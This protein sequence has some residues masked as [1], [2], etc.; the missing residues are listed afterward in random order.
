ME[1]GGDV[2]GTQP[3]PVP[4]VRASRDGGKGGAIDAHGRREGDERG[5]SDRERV[6]QG[7]PASA[8]PKSEAAATKKGSRERCTR[9]GCA[10]GSEGAGDEDSGVVGCAWRWCCT[11]AS[12][13]AQATSRAPGAWRCSCVDDSPG[14]QRDATF[15]LKSVAVVARRAPAACAADAGGSSARRGDKGGAGNKGGL[16]QALHMRLAV[17]SRRGHRAAGGRGDVGS[18][19]RQHHMLG[20]QMAAL[21]GATALEPANHRNVR[22]GEAWASCVGVVGRQGHDARSTFGESVVAW[23]LTRGVLPAL[24]V[25]AA[26]VVRYVTAWRGPTVR[27]RNRA[28]CSRGVMDAGTS[29]ASAVAEGQAQR[30]ALL[31]PTGRQIGEARARSGEVE[32]QRRGMREQP[33]RIE[34]E[35]RWIERSRGLAEP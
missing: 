20:V 6:E 11:S 33:V 32:N 5:T 26:H 24:L 16:G 30:G 10:N 27:I 28:R 23:R 29:A 1:Q 4:L 8:G 25:V 17:R 35:W 19:K 7:L 14:R 21:V 31:V 2:E 15:E 3:E 18:E 9:G 12:P 34:P 22:V 13:G